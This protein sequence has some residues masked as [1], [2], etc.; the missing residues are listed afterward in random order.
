MGPEFFPGDILFRIGPIFIGLVFIIVIG[1]ILF[2]VVKGIGQWQKNNASP[3]LSVPAQAVSKR[4]HV[5]RRAQAHNDHM[6]SGS[7]TSYFVTFEFESGDR[8]ELQV[9]GR[10]YGQ[11]VEGD[12]GTLTFQGTR[13]LGFERGTLNAVR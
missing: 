8:T 1:G 6:H 9:D 2:T 12:S 10:E 4:T 11:I 3:R 13:Y 5:S 7:R